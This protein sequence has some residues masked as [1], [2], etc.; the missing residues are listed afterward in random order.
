MLYLVS[1][2]DDG[3]TIFLGL[4]TENIDHIQQDDPL[5][6]RLS[7]CNYPGFF[8]LYTSETSAL[9]PKMQEMEDYFAGLGQY[10]VLGATNSQLEALR[11]NE[12]CFIFEPEDRLP[13][14]ARI[15]ILFC[16][17]Q[18]ELFRALKANGAISDR[19][20]VRYVPKDI[21]SN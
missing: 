19:T 11:R 5:I 3:L 17:D 7:H 21:L 10:A 20:E 12:G 18:K 9:S 2:G 4:S 16:S 15:I 8:F 1:Q 13:G 14:V 6:A